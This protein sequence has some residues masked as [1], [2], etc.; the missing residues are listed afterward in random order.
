M[1]ESSNSS[2]FVLIPLSEINGP[3]W[4]IKTSWISK[5]VFISVFKFFKFL[6]FIPI[7]ASLNL[8]ALFASSTVWTSTIT[9]SSN[10][11]ASL[12]KSSASLSLT[13]ANIIKIASAT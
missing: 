13:P 4:S 5:V 1:F 7:K 12:Y 3:G 11:S 9:D 8:K 10:L 6:L 2:S